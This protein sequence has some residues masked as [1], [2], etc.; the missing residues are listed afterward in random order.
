MEKKRDERQ[1]NFELMVLQALVCICFT[2]STMDGIGK[3][4]RFY[5]IFQ[6]I[7]LLS[8]STNYI[9]GDKK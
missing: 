2:L 7:M 1:K 6:G 3:Y 8:A 5:L 4:F 9:W